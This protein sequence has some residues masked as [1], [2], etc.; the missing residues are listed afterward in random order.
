MPKEIYD[1]KLSDEEE[2]D[3]STLHEFGCG[4]EECCGQPNK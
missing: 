2:V 4:C 3:E 1:V